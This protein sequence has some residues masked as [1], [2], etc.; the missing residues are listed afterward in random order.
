MFLLTSHYLPIIL[1]MI[2]LEIFQNLSGQI[3]FCMAGR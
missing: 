3:M 2:P 1:K